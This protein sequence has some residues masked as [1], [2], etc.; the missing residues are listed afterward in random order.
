LSST[1]TRSSSASPTP[2]PTSCRDSPSASCH[3]ANIEATGLAEARANADPIGTGPYRLTSLNVNRAQLERNTSYHRGAPTIQ[4]LELRFYPNSTL[5]LEALAQG[6]IDAAL[7]GEQPDPREGE[8]IL[9]R[10]E[11]LATPLIRHAFTVLY[12]NNQQAPLSDPA[13]RRAIAALID[14]GAVIRAA[15]IRGLAGEG[16]IVPRS[17][18]KSAPPEDV[19]PDLEPTAAWVAAGYTLDEDGHLARNGSALSLELLTNA[20][21]ARVRLAEAVATALAAAGVTVEVT[22]LPASDLLARRLVPRD[23][24]LALFGWEANIDPDP[25]LG[26]H[27]SQISETGRN[28]AGYQDATADALLEAARLTVDA[29]ERRELYAAFEA[30]FDEQAASVILAYPSRLYVHPGSLD[31]FEPGL[32]FT[33]AD[34]FRDIHLWSL[35]AQDE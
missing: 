28:I 7:R 8:V 21:P 35:E 26:W 9:E 22:P 10:A 32:L 27:T 17:W 33:A 11:L 34:R 2:R 6:E 29:A 12:L 23:F 5:Q 24:E 31:G 18:L 13:L 14:P 3:Y 15:S 30:R 20:D 1:N 4:R 19:P 25:Y 16:V